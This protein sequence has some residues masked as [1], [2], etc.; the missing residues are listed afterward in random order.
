MT[1]VPGRF[2]ANDCVSSAV[3]PRWFRLTL[4]ALIRR[5]N[6]AI[7]TDLARPC[8]TNARVKLSQIIRNA[9][10]QPLRRISRAV[11]EVSVSWSVGG[12]VQLKAST[13]HIWT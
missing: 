10:S 12:P 5:I 6:R 2:F 3:R 4:A 11:M 13:G 1:P 9:W 7:M 8:A